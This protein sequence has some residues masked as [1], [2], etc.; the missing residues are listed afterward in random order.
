MLLLIVLI[1]NF[2]SSETYR[3]GNLSESVKIINA[4]TVSQIAI[5]HRLEKIKQEQERKHNTALVGAYA[6]R[7]QQKKLVLKE[8]KITKQ[9]CLFD[10]KTHQLR[11][12]R[13]TEEKALKQKWAIALKRQQ[14]M[15]QKQLVARQ[16]QLQKKLLQQEMQREQVQIAK[17]RSAQFQGVLNQY[18]V[19]VIQAIQQQWIVPAAGANKNLSCVLLIR[20]AP[21]GAVLNIATMRNSGEPVLDRSARVAVFKASP[22]P[23]P[24]DSSAFSA[25]R[26]LRLTMRPLH[27]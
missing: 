27:I 2:S 5:D 13:K 15:K 17:T 18:K 1:F 22:L 4:V 19:K 25:F 20:L 10:L 12:Q 23:V 21:S 26:E 8:Q 24:K 14:E 11:L 16:Q 6:H 7:L 9:K 3:T